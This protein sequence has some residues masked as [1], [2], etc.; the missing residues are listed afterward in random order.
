MKT[1]K[2]LREERTDLINSIGEAST[3]QELCDIHQQIVDKEDEM[4]ARMNYL[5]EQIDK[6][7]REKD[8]SSSGFDLMTD[9]TYLIGKGLLRI[10]G[11]QP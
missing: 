10:H 11:K 1:L 3:S 7:K 5:D 2:E 8:E 4:V 9:T 6:L